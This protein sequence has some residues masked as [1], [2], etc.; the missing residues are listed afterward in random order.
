MKHQLRLYFTIL[1]TVLFL[2]CNKEKNDL[3][4]ETQIAKVEPIIG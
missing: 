4:Y 1:S 3:I 2:S